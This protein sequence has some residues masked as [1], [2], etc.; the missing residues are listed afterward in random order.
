MIVTAGA[1][2]RQA[3]QSSTDGVH[4][5]FPLIGVSV[6]QNEFRQCHFLVI[7]R[8]EPLK[9]E[10]R[11][12]FRTGLFK[13]IRR[14]LPHDEF[15]IRNVVVQRLNDPVSIPPGM[16]IRPVVRSHVRVV[17]RV[18]GDVEPVPRPSLAIARRIQQPINQFRERV[19]RSI[20]QKLVTLLDR[21]RQSGQIETRSPQQRV[22]I[23]AVGVRQSGLFLLRQDKSIDRFLNPLR[24]FYVGS[25]VPFRWLQRPV[26]P[27]KI[28]VDLLSRSRGRWSVPRISSAHRN[29]LLKIGN[30]LVRQLTRRWHLIRILAVPNRLNQQTLIQLPR[31]DRR[32]GITTQLRAL[33]TVQQQP[34][35]QLPVR[36]RLRGVTLVALL[37]QNRPDLLL[38]EI[39]C[40]RVKPR[41]LRLCR[42]HRDRR[43]E[44][45]SL[46]ETDNQNPH[47][48]CS[49][50][51]GQI[52]NH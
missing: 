9:A 44:D 5:V 40:H 37:N 38:K 16:R 24:V 31:N 36:L 29:P 43:R 48:G 20:A 22:T 34:T 51:K 3:Q 26:L 19:R 30:H 39:E 10:C 21:R 52:N 15:V 46:N 17:F 7:R 47:Q 6:L 11:V 28:P 12:I 41:S 1:G 25:G 4:A 32:S 35:L 42:M 33:P 18:A 45:K 27:S 14:E 13:E 50:D 2:Q 49:D 23:R 8:G